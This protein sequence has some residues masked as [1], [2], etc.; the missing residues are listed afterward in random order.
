MY[1]CIMYVCMY[2]HCHGKSLQHNTRAAGGRL[3]FKDG[4]FSYS[5]DAYAWYLMSTNTTETVCVYTEI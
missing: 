2:V 5:F 1:V 4:C 3:D